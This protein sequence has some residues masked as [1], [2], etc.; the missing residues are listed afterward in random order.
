MRFCVAYDPIIAATGDTGSGNQSSTED[1]SLENL[2]QMGMSETLGMYE[3]G[4]VLGEGLF[5]AVRM[6]R[7]KLAH[8]DVAIKCL[9]RE[10]CEKFGLR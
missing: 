8:V 6:A 7:H 5:G 10:A 2:S 9:A 3:L 1:E 4:V